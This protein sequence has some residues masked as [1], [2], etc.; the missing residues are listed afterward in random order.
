MKEGKGISI[1]KFLKKK[2]GD[3]NCHYFYS[4]SDTSTWDI[5]ISKSIDGEKIAEKYDPDSMVLI[6]VQVPINNHLIQD[7]ET[8]GNIRLFYIDT[9]KE[10]SYDD[11]IQKEKKATLYTEGLRKR[12]VQN[13]ILNT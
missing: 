2:E 5:I 11:E 12:D 3:S 8:S 1:F 10:V 4:K 9:K 7:D 6:C 13:K